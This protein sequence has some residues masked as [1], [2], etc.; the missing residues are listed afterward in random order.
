MS[1][2]RQVCTFFVEGQLFGV[3]LEQV[4]EILG[5]QLLTRVPLAPVELA[6]LLNLRGNI[7]PA[8]DLRR[9]LALAERDADSLHSHIVLRGEDGVVSLLVDEVGDI[10]MVPGELFE[11]PP[12]HLQGT[13]RE[14]LLG[15]YKLHS[16]LLLMLSPEAAL[17]LSTLPQV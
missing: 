2:T 3:A 13:L 4:Q 16:Q 9:R 12:S 5:T 14:V 7:V 11:P 10:L 17:E 15:V 1:D 8:V 6:G